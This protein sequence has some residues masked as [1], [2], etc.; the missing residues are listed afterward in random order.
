MGGPVSQA[1]DDAVE[2]L[3][4]LGYPCISSAGNLDIPANQSSPASAPRAIVVGASEMNNDKMTDFTNWGVKVD[5]FAPGRR[6]TSCDSKGRFSSVA[7]S[8]YEI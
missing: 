2:A 6:V 8:G 5:L 4:D 7:Y 1:M 3:I